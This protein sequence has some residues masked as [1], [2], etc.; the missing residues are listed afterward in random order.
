MSEKY[1]S[2]SESIIEY[3][4]SNKIITRYSSL[5]FLS[6]N[7]ILYMINYLYHRTKNTLCSQGVYP[8]EF[9][10]YLNQFIIYM[11]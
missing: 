7:L 1:L 9:P 10:L 11:E 5:Y 8:V 3:N 2:L 4:L 6:L